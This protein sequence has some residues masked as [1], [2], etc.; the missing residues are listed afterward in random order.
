MNPVDTLPSHLAERSRLVETTR[1]T[2]ASE[3]DRSGKSSHADGPVLWWVHHAMRVEENPALDVARELATR[4]DRP[5]LPV[6][7]VGG[8]HR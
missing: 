1:A 6:A 8:R 7:V 3:A 5:L 2:A 4:L